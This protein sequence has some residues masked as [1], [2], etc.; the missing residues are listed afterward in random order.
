M[1]I[2]EFIDRNAEELA[3]TSIVV[4][5]AT[6]VIATSYIVYSHDVQMAKLGYVEQAQLGT[7]KTIWVKPK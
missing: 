4:T 1:T 3:I 6:I 2:R 5:I 7:S